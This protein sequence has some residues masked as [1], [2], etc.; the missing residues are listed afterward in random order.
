MLKEEEVK[1]MIDAASNKRD[2]AV[3]A[4]LW[5]IGARTVPFA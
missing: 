2:R 5:D 1:R 4:L 3:I